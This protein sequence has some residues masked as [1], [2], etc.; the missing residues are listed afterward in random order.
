[1]L[2]GGVTELDLPELALNLLFE[3]PRAGV[4]TAAWLL[5]DTHGLWCLHGAPGSLAAAVALLSLPKLLSFN[6]AV[7][8]QRQVV[9]VPTFA[10][11]RNQPPLLDLD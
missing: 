7:M 8:G 9:V 2:S 5:V 10:A 1:M 4:S 6:P 3:A 11:W